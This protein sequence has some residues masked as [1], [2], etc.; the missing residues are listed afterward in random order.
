MHRI[1]R[2]LHAASPNLYCH[3][4]LAVSLGL[5]GDSVRRET[6]RVIETDGVKAVRSACTMCGGTKTV[7]TADLRLLKV[8]AQE[9]RG[10]RRLHGASDL[11][12]IPLA[13]TL[14]RDA[15]LCGDC[16]ARKTGVPRWKMGDVVIHLRTTGKVSSNVARCASCLK[17]TVVHR[18]G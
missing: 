17:Q 1:A 15:S 12:D 18:L 8:R 7:V 13:A 10:A 14:S 11:D 2:F 5:D 3:D 9:M 16:L 6:V 4:C